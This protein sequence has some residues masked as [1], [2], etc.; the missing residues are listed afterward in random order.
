MARWIKI[1]DD[2]LNSPKAQRLKPRDFWR[3]FV[4]AARGEESD[5]SEF[6]RPCSGRL[7]ASQWSVI[8]S[9]IFSRDNFTCQYCGARGGR[10]EC[11]HIVPLSRGGSDEDD[12]LATSCKPCNRSKRAK[13]PA[14]WRP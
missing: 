4:S 14:E 2:L 9:R 7:P 10:L 6:V 11:D 5:L 13:T 3:E 12:N 8:R 1:N